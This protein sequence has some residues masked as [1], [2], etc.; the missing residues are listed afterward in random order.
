VQRSEV[1]FKEEQVPPK[2]QAVL[3]PRVANGIWSDW[4]KVFICGKSRSG[5]YDTNPNLVAEIQEALT[6]RGYYSGPINN[7]MTRKT[8]KALAKFKEDK[9]LPSGNVETFKAL[10]L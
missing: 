5:D 6:M 8:K 4:R 2:Y 9:G 3:V 10:G 7:K 1:V